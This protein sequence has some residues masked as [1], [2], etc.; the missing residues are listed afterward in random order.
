MFS[1]HLLSLSL[2]SHSVDLLSPLSLSPLKH[3]PLPLIHTI[4][5]HFSLFLLF[6]FQSVS[7]Y[8][9]LFYLAL[10]CLFSQ[11]FFSLLPSLCHLSTTPLF[12]HLILFSL[13]FSPTPLFSSLYPPKISVTLTNSHF[14]WRN[15]H[16]ILPP[17]GDTVTGI[18]PASRELNGKG[19]LQCWQIGE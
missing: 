13:F 2:F 10:F 7:L 16:L 12:F 4:L 3:F 8:T 5:C 11:Q 19:V 9:P 14:S 17:R 1:L 15:P 18:Q 6:L